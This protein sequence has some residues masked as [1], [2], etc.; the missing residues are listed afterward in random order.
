MAENADTAFVNLKRKII[1]VDKLKKHITKTDS[2]IVELSKN[3]R[4]V[5]ETIF[6][7]T[8]SSPEGCPPCSSPWIFP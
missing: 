4:K 8:F 3:S 6:I 5:E 7:L 2:K 1:A